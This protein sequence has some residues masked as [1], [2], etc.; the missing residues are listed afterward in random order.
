MEYLFTD[1]EARNY[2]F[3]GGAGT[4]L[5]CT[6]NVKGAL[7][8]IGPSSRQIRTAHKET[9]HPIYSLLIA[10]IEG[11]TLPRICSFSSTPE[12]GSASVRRERS[13]GKD[14]ATPDQL[15]AG[16]GE[17]VLMGFRFLCEH[18]AAFQ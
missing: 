1:V 17:S 16:G 6:K 5:I 7:T 8:I 14:A 15:P 18:C 10:G 12:I 2:T 11:S 4:S 9:C 13:V 3:G